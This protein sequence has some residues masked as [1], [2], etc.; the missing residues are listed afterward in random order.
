MDK[1]TRRMFLS[2]SVPPPPPVRS[3]TVNAKNQSAQPESA[4]CHFIITSPRLCSGLSNSSCHVYSTNSAMDLCLFDHTSTQIPE[5]EQLPT[6]TP[7]RLWTGKP[8]AAG[9]TEST[10]GLWEGE[11]K[12]CYLIFILKPAEYIIECIIFITVHARRLTVIYNLRKG[13]HAVKNVNENNC[14]DLKN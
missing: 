12:C 5:A 9:F 10:E 13:L 2:R 8:F 6:R 14:N 3:N 4:L 7:C 11:E 1:R